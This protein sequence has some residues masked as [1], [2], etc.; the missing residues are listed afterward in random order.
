MTWKTEPP[1]IE[2]LHALKDALREA[3][4][5]C[6]ATVEL[7]P[8]AL[9]TA[10]PAGRL[11]SYPQRWLTIT[12]LTDEDVLGDGWQRLLHPMDR[13]RVIAAWSDA[14]A[15]GR[16]FDQEYRF[17][18]GDG[19]Y[20]WVWTRAV[21]RRDEQG[22][23]IRWY[24]SNEDIHQR[25]LAEEACQ[26]TEVE[27]ETVTD[28][29]PM[30]IALVGPDFIYRF[31]NRAYEDW[32]HVERDT[33]VGNHISAVIG[34]TAFIER[35]PQMQRALAGE[36]ILFEI[37]ETTPGGGVRE[38]EMRYLPHHTSEG[39]IDG[40][41]IFG[42]DVTGRKQAERVLRDMNE[43]L[44]RRID[45]RTAALRA[46][47][48][49]RQQTEE[50]LRQA[51]KMETI[52]QLTGGIAHDFNNLLTGI[53]GGL[54]LLQRRVSAGRTAEIL[55]L[56]D[57]A[58]GSAQR[59]V[60]LTQRLLTFSRRQSLS[61]ERVDL[62][63][64]LG[65]I[66]SLLAGTLKEQIELAISTEEGLW[67]VD[68]DAHQI[69]S[70]LLNLA[71]NARDAM[72]QGGKLTISASNVRFETDWSDAMGEVKAGDY[73][74]LNVADTG[75]GMTSA[76]IAKAFDPFFTTKPQGH[77]TGL[78]LSIVY[79]FVR[80]SGGH[81]AIES[82]INRGTC[83]KLFLPRFSREDPPSD[84][85]NGVRRRPEAGTGETVLVVEDDP[86]VRA[87][88]LEA[89][90]DLGYS[91]CE[92]SDGSTA[93]L[94][95]ESRARIDLLVTDVGLPGLSGRDLALAA[96]GHRPN[97]KILFITGYAEKAASADVLG[98]SDT[99]IIMKPFSLDAVGL[100]IRQMIHGARPA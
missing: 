67:P 24:G 97:L 89:L 59:A 5:H 56:A 7:S 50:A 9:W 96:R 78:G 58:M 31:A 25:K 81:V 44:E 42:T 43:I 60:A 76:V 37:S 91:G 98:G 53:I 84:N 27:L 21:P 51:Q 68:T 3:E 32:F 64:L 15:T 74:L 86:T 85:I 88:L 61:C 57:L 10:D 92:A 69:E 63:R 22:N 94:M 20:H 41:Y 49:E 79:R 87:L 11:L 19:F 71:V 4:E 16:P 82:E 55:P 47:M 54:E 83:V 6:R 1:D 2:E 14:L 13:D 33:V 48:I 75:T 66:H 40:L 29:V 45:E 52:G 80:Q 62:D 8:V 73:V 30:L 100:K 12:G 39:E 77:G 36:R 18:F 95:L 38:A 23:I 46:E 34:A 93:L 70:A 17:R 26:G 35:L 65:A 90:A 28:V 99:D 72:P